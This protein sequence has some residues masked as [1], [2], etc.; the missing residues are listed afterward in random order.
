MYYIIREEIQIELHPNNM[1]RK[2]GT[3]LSQS[4]KLLIYSLK[5]WR[6]PPPKDMP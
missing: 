1:N 5:Q 3:C 2:D 6:K 4:W